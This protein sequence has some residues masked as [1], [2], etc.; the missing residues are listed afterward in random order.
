M[1]TV[2]KAAAAVAAVTPVAKVAAVAAVAAAAEAD[3]SA[4]SLTVRTQ[5]RLRELILAG[6]LLPGVRIPE[7]ALVDRLGVS[8][9]PVRAALV[10]LAEEGLLEALSGG[11]FAVRDFSET[12]ICDAIELRGTLEGLAARLAAQR[13]PSSVVLLGL[14]DAVDRIDALLAPSALS[15]AA[16]VAYGEQNARFHQLLAE[17]A[18][19]AVVQRQ[20]ARVVT[21]PFASPNAFVLQRASGPDARDALVV[22][23]AQHRVVLDAI[24]RRDAARADAVMQEH[25]RLAHANLRQALQSQQGLLNLQKLP[26][27][28]LIRHAGR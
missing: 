14:Q 6:E 10:R 9:T 4:G 18:G 16:F 2:R 15:D 17:A 28:R 5:L 8:R 1:T 7:L 26:G 21:L 25:A 19:S 24:L 11:G 22:A 20:I 13:G 12:D 23:Q 27:A 3:D